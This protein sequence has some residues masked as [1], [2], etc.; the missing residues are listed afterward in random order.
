MRLSLFRHDIVKVA[1]DP[2]GAIK[3][4]QWAREN[5]VSYYKKN[6]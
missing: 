1:V 4:S 2:Q 3:I 5:F 6:S